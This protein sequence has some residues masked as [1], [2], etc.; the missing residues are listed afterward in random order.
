MGELD[1]NSYYNLKVTISIGGTLGKLH[2]VEAGYKSIFRT[3]IEGLFALSRYVC[4]YCLKIEHFLSEIR[5]IN[6]S[7]L[8]RGEVTLDNLLSFE[9]KIDMENDATTKNYFTDRLKVAKNLLIEKPSFSIDG[10]TGYIHLTLG[11]TYIFYSK[12]DGLDI[13]EEL[14]EKELLRRTE[15]LEIIRAIKSSG[16]LWDF[17]QGDIIKESNTVNPIRIILN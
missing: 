2:S 1:S 17:I 9:E 6:E 3:K 11:V 10:I 7:G 8:A 16:L 15:Y 14:Y 4:E 12:K 13:A 5:I